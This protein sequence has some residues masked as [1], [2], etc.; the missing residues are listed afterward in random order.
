MLSISMT[1]ADILG[2]VIINSIAFSDIDKIQSRISRSATLDGGVVIVNSG[3]IH[4]DRTFQISEKVSRSVAEKI[5][6]IQENSVSILCSTREGLFLGVI[7]ETDYTNGT[8]KT[9]ILIKNKE[10]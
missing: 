8:L 2:N 4:G 1:T 7:S 5:K 3:T 6:Y 9:T 10:N